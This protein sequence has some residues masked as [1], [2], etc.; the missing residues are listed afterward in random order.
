MSQIQSTV[1]L[2]TGV[3]ITQTV[4]QLIALSARPRDL[5]TRRNQGLTTEQ[6][7]IN[8]LS[9]LVLGLQFDIRKLQDADLF[10]QTEVST[11]NPD[12]LNAV[13]TS[14]TSPPAGQFQFTAVQTATAHQLLS[15]SFGPDAT[16]QGLGDFTIRS[17]GFIDPSIELAELN[18]G[19]G[20]ARGKIRITDRR[21]DSTT[22]DLGY[23]RNIDDVLDAIN[24]NDAINV[25]AEVDGDAIKLVDR[26][27]GA[28]SSNLRVQEVGGG[29]TAAD[30]GLANIDTPLSEALGND[31]YGIHSATRLSDLNDGTGVALV[32]ELGD[33]FVAFRDET[34][35]NIDLG[36]ATTIGDVLDA[37]N[38]ADP[39]KLTAAI[40]QDGDRLVLT[41]LTSGGGTFVIQNSTGSTAADELGINGESSSGTVT[42]RRI[43]SGLK[44]TLVSTLGGGEGIGGLGKLSLTDRNQT[45][46]VIDLSTAETVDDIIATINAAET[47]FG[48][49]L[50]ITASVNEARNGILLTDTSGA[51]ASNLIV[52]N[53]GPTN[54]ADRLGI[55]ID[56]AVS[57]VDSGSLGRRTIGLSTELAALNG[58]RGVRL[59][60]FLIINS[61]GQTS[62]IKLNTTGEEVTTVGGVIDV[63][64][65]LDN[66]VIARINDAGD[67]ILLVDTLAGAE[68]LTIEEVSGTTAADLGFT[69]PVTISD[70]GNG[71]RQTIDGSATRSFSVARGISL[72]SI[73]GG[74]DVDRFEITDSLGNIE[75]FDLDESDSQS[76]G[77]VIDL[78]NASSIR[79]EA[80]LNDAGDGLTLV[81]T[82]G[83]NDTLTVRERGGTTASD[84]GILGAGSD[85]VV[86][87]ETIHTLQGKAVFDATDVDQA[88][89]NRVAQ[90][91]N[92][93]DFGVAASTF[94]DGQGYRLSLVA[95]TSGNR[96]ELLVDSRGGGFNFD[97]ITAARDALLL[98][99]TSDSSA[100]G[101]IIASSDNTFADVVSG[102]ELTL[103]Q[104]SSEPVTVR[105]DATNT[106]VLDAVQ[107]FVD[108]YNSVR[109]NL[110]TVTEFDEV[111]LTTG[112]LFGSIEALRVDS[113]L[114]QLVT[115][116]HFGLGTYRTLQELGIG[117]DDKGKLSLDKSRL[118]E[119]LAADPESVITFF[120]Q[121]GTEN[122]PKGIVAKF[123]AV[124]EQ[125]AGDES[126][127][128]ANRSESL[129]RR[130]EVNNERIE[131][132]NSI[133]DSQ[134]Q[135]LLK[136][137]FQM[138]SIVGSLQS[139]VA[140]LQSLTII[141]PAS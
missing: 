82:G 25:S 87:E 106:P 108:A 101:I 120:T 117:I 138:E 43:L 67:G 90:Q 119:A 49:K 37:F 141:P 88:A 13:A 126:S 92:D 70:F 54:T 131:R 44:S 11:G 74:V 4:D 104:A 71:K 123:D 96:G 75:T 62:A 136:E 89:L 6:V 51:T 134:R 35:L 125:L 46:T 28:V 98:L 47:A 115:S 79:V 127:L 55:A 59:G 95:S 65:A 135:R 68:T 48:V 128:L 15:S 21:G 137:F 2:F 94:F 1:G 76:I 41:D 33:V 69:A 140:A 113:D 85:E 36:S 16:P 122:E 53:A 66:G 91:I 72:A 61:E 99:G 3:P 64:N 97:E 5:I 56:D 27:T 103:N 7:A 18:Q 121:E 112:Q 40:S 39:A 133:L 30:L 105:V 100:S 8:Q 93:R 110:D 32:S 73:G 19:T 80:R 60:S 77:D 12:I 139:N 118:E 10:Q 57:E 78:I 9:S 116:R 81:D 129:E 102:V 14:E 26:N 52:A 124:I 58:G 111:E 63:I 86:G 29:R 34:S 20:V 107:D 38:A 132:M 50:Q 84:L 23:A 22:V 109:E 24:S 114:S 130:I 42:G 31:I 83:G 45:T 17:G